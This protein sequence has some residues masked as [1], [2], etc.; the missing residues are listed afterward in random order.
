MNC[1]HN[2]PPFLYLG[3]HIEGDSRKLNLWYPL[4]DRIKR[5]LLGWKVEIR[6]WGVV[7]H[8]SLFSCGEEWVVL[9]GGR[10]M[11]CLVAECE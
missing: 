1:K 8:T 10:K 7:L 2:R 6:Q 3:L 5:M 9:F 11:V 4:V